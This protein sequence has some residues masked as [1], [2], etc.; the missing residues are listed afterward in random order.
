VSTSA[1][2]NTAGTCNVGRDGG[3][4]NDAASIVSKAAAAAGSSSCTSFPLEWPTPAVKG[5]A[6]KVG[7][8]TYFIGKTFKHFLP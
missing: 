2:I 7:V 6:R 5:K 3:N 4:T 1:L 8:T